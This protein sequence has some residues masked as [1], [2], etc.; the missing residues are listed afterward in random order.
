VS[1]ERLPP[2]PATS[3]R[4]AAAWAFPLVTFLVVVIGGAILQRDLI[5]WPGPQWDSRI[6]LHAFAIMAAGG[7]PYEEPGFVYT[8]PCA[9]AGT[10][11]Y[12]ALG[13]W[14]LLVALRAASLVGLWLLVWASLA[15]IRW[16]LSARAIAAL[17]VV[18]SPLVGN[19]LGAA[20]L[21][22]VLNGPLMAALLFAERWPLASGFVAATA[23]V[24]KPVGASAM[25]VLVTPQRGRR[26]AAWGPQFVIGAAAAGLW[27]LVGSR[28]L[29]SMLGRVGGFPDRVRNVSLARVFYVFGLDVNPL[30]IFAAVTALGMVFA[31]LR[32]ISHR[33]RLAVAGTTTLLA[34]PV[35][36]PHTFLLTLPAQALALERALTRLAAARRGRS[37]SRRALAEVAL[38]VG[39]IVDV[40]GSEG[41]TTTGELPLL[42]QGMVTLMPLVAIT[43]LTVYGVECDQ[44]DPEVS[45]EAA[46]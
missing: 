38:V 6:Y 10:A 9:V 12:R 14:G 27:L 1:A 39:A 2:A 24:L 42:V 8:P 40:H 22:M 5:T 3:R 36:N 7:D 29:P 20:N 21:S 41:A 17:M 15:R 18:L 25:A 16:S 11:I 19:G 44:L 32:V 35:N 45:A 33:Q 31:W 13:P 26:L 4:G 46:P 30:G 34:L 28:Y 37:N 43:A 23:N